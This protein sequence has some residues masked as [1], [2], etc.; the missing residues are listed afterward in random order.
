MIMCTGEKPLG[1]D[2]PGGLVHI[3]RAEAPSSLRLNPVSKSHFPTS[4]LCQLGAGRE[5]PPRSLS[6]KQG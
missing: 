3:C 1:Q 5:P 6:V 4:Q 2:W